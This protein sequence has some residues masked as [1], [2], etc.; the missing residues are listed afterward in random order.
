MFLDYLVLG[1]GNTGINLGDAVATLVIFLGLMA[2]LKKFAWGPLMGIMRERE[3]LV[4][5]GIDA[6]EKAKKET[7]A[8][9]EEQKSLLKEARTEAQSIL[10]G[11]K[12][13]G[14]AS[15]EEIVSAARAEANRLKES[16]VRDIEAEKERTKK[17]IN[18][19]CKTLTYTTA[20]KPSKF[21]QEVVFLDDEDDELRHLERNLEDAYDEC[22]ITGVAPLHEYFTEWL[23]LDEIFTYTE[24]AEMAMT[25]SA[26]AMGD[27]ITNKFKVIHEWTEK[28]LDDIWKE[29]IWMS[30]DVQEVM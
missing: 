1:A 6:A 3:E 22:Q 15:R 14:E 5:S 21:K 30:L 23:A 2:L 11:A 25:E 4:A 27:L 18:K 24:L 12:K 9:L 28:E 10:E 17:E 7:Q 8:L 20:Y 16:A 26:K 19:K 13:Q 29:V